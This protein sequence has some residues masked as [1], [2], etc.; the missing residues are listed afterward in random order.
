MRWVVTGRTSN[1]VANIIFMASCG[2]LRRDWGAGCVVEVMD[3]LWTPRG[4]LVADALTQVCPVN[5]P[6]TPHP[7]QFSDDLRDKVG[8]GGGDV[9]S[10]VY[11]PRISATHA[12][13]VSGVEGTVVNTDVSRVHVVGVAGVVVKLRLLRESARVLGWE[14]GEGLDNLLGVSVGP[15]VGCVVRQGVMANGD[16]FVVVDELKLCV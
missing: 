9:L 11:A 4:V 14:D 8:G 2:A 15:L 5:P 6:P 13:V 1:C 10:E 12:L 7:L 3:A 16:P